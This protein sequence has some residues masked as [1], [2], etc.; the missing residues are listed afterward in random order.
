MNLMRYMPLSKFMTFKRVYDSEEQA[1]ALSEPEERQL[2]AGPAD[3][4]MFARQ[5]HSV[6]HWLLLNA[7]NHQ[8]CAS[9]QRLGGGP[10]CS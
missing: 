2:C 7:I 9:C 1:R 8:Y 4:H 3:S 5:F 6:G 10:L